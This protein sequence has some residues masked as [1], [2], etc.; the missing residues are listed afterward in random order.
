LS[1]KKTRKSDKFIGDLAD[2]ASTETVE[3]R[4]MMV[5]PAIRARDRD[6]RGS[7]LESPSLPAKLVAGDL[8]VQIGVK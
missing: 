6:L 8:T 4:G 7:R 3:L 5:D 2:G 1:R